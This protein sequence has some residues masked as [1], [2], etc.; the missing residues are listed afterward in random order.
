[1]ANSTRLAPSGI[2]QPIEQLILN[3]SI[4]N[5]GMETEAEFIFNYMM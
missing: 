2:S 4:Q 5:M 1:M 3:A